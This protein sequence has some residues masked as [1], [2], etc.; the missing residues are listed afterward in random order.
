MPRSE[1]A[2][3]ARDEGGSGS[4]TIPKLSS[5]LKEKKFLTKAIKLN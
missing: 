1:D 3:V 4:F 2:P 5:Q